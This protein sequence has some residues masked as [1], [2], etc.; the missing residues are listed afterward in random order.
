[1]PTRPGVDMNTFKPL[2]KA[3]IRE[4]WRLQSDLP[5]ILSCMRNQAR[6]LFCEILDS[7]A[8]YKTKNLDDPI[9]Q[10]AVFL[11]HSSG[12]DAGQEYWLHL[13][14]LSTKEWMPHYCKDLLKSVLHTYICDACGS[15]HIDYMIKLLQ[16]RFENGR[17][18][19]ECVNCKQWAARTPNTNLGYSRE[20]MAE[21]FNLADLYVQCSIAGADEMPA[22]ER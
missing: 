3:K 8:D 17:A 15:K 21:V 10:K 4:K 7:F 6:K 18:Y 16:P 9:A 22:T 2:D 14:R 19:I 12:Y 11:I 20:D 13:L 5:I 1:M